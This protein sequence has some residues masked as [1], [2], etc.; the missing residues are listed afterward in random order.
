[1]KGSA[2]APDP[3]NRATF[4]FRFAVPSDLLPAVIDTNQRLA[5]LLPRLRAA[6]WV[7]MDTEADSLHAYP[8]KLCLVQ[9]N[10]PDGQVLVDPLAAVD[11]APMLELLRGKASDRML[12]LFACACMRRIWLRM[13]EE[14]VPEEVEV[15]E[16]FADGEASKACVFPFAPTSGS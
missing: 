5:E 4:G 10:L 7:A 6:A 13:E 12:R 15:S 3:A 8:E 1:M 14:E 2:R 16:R 11:L 9:L